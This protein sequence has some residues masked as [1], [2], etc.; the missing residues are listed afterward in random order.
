MQIPDSIEA[1]FFRVVL[2]DRSVLLHCA[3]YR[4]QWQ[5]S[6]PINYLS[7]YCNN[8]LTL[9][10][11]QSSIIVVRDLNQHLTQRAFDSL[12]SGQGPYDHVTFST[13]VLGGTL[14]TV[15]SDLGGQSR[16]CLPLTQVGPSTLI[17][18]GS[19]IVLT[20]A[21]RLDCHQAFS[22]THRLGGS[23]ESSENKSLS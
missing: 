16:K 3:L 5:C 21:R 4:P 9:H 23:H 11:C 14:D 20:F 19:Q 6:D 13:R 7:E 17:A 12:L 8:L 22:A 10:K 15:L 1:T 2:K 18:V